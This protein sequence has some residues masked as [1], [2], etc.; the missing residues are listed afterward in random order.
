MPLRHLPG[1]ISLLLAT[2]LAAAEP[3]K[4][5]THKLGWATVVL[6]ATTK[7]NEPVQVVLTVTRIPD[8]TATKVHLD[9]HYL[10]TAGVN[11]GV[12]ASDGGK[13]F[14][15]NQPLT[16]TIKPA[17]KTDVGKLLPILFASTDG[18]WAGKLGEHQKL[19]LIEVRQ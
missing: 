11:K 7:A 13:A 3:A 5:Q 19:P 6:P 2:G 17:G 10:D 14:T 4:T 15:L 8:K 1:I 18:T 12:Y 16:W 9:L